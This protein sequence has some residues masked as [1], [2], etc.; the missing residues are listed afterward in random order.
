M[1][2]LTCCTAPVE[3][4]DLRCIDG[5]SDPPLALQLE[6]APTFQTARVVV[7]ATAT[8]HCA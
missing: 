3:D 4:M 6:A 8:H 7:I 2:L 5:L 1:Q